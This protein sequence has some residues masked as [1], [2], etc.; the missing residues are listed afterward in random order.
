VTS[1]WTLF[2]AGWKTTIAAP[3]LVR[4]YVSDVRQFLAWFEQHTGEPFALLAVTEYDVRAWR[5]TLAA[6]SKPATVN[7]KLASLASLYRWAADSGQA[8]QDPTRHIGGIAQQATAPKALSEQTVTKIMRKVHQAD[9]RRDI[10][11]LELL[12]ATGLRVSDCRRYRDRESAW[13]FGSG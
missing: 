1:L 3:I 12:A 8:K 7:R 11:L 13:I 6:K 9:N 2:V 10:A 5:D 4:A